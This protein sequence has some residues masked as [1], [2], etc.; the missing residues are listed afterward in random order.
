MILISD[1]RK[2]ISEVKDLIREYS[3]WLGRDLSFQDIDSELHNPSVKYA[4]P[5]GELL[6]ALDGEKVLGMVAYHRL[7]A[8]TCEMKRLY[9]R[10][11]A[12]GIG[13]GRRLAAEIISR[14]AAAGYSEMVLDTIEPLRAAISLYKSLGFK[15]CEAYYHNP[16]SDVIYFMKELQES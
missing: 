16:M 3:L 12:R 14:A 15:E 10:P 9:V 7:S 8:E 13:L 5:E 1:G 4:P 11:E 6:V 2:H